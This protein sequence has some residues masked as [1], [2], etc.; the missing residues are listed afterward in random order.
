[1]R[2]V[3]LTGFSGFDSVSVGELPDPSPGDGEVVVKVAAAGVG[4]WDAKTA[5]GVFA[6]AHGNAGFPQVLGWDVAGTVDVGDSGGRWHPG[7]EVLGFVHQPW[8]H[9]GSF[10]EKMVIPA[11]HLARR[12][13][14][15]DPVIAGATPVI[16]LTAEQAVRAG[17]VAKGATILV[18]GAAGNLGTLILQMAAAEGARVI[19]SIRPEQADTVRALGASDVVD[20][21]GSVP[22]QVH[23]IVPGGVDGLIDLVGA[24]AWKPA[25]GAVRQGGYFASTVS[26]ELPDPALGLTSTYIWV[27]P[28]MERLESLAERVASGELTIHVGE[29]VPMAG[30]PDA[31]RRAG[32]GKTNGRLVL[33]PQG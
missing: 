9:Q 30:G 27:Q 29:K 24:Q 15:L 8:A 14:G 10:A 3:V 19:A 33:V 31:V 5:F 23:A 16:A 11:D 22:D 7:D 12:P 26:Q 18:L 20:R 1:M 17:G 25:I 4:A 13:A 32:E 28:D 6:Q 21:D 2:G